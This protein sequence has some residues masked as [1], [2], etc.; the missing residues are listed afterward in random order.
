MQKGNEIIVQDYGTDCKNCERYQKLGDVCLVEHGKKFSWEYCRDFDP[1]VVLPDYKDLMKSV[2]MDQALERRK[3]KDKKDKEKRKKLKE[4]KERDELKKKNRRAKLRK[5][6]ERLKKLSEKN[7]KKGSS[8]SDISITKKHPKGKSL[9]QSE[10][11]IA[12]DSQIESLKL[13]ESPAPKPKKRARK[14]T[15]NNLAEQS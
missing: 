5:R 8:L 11:S 15:G 3:L 14:A 7:T 6:R 13:P 9:S 1:R 10:N 4:K 12:N 2:R